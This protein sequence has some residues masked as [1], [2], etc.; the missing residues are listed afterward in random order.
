MRATQPK[1][2]V[3]SKR[4]KHAKALVMQPVFRTRQEKARKGKGSYQRQTRSQSDW[5]G[6]F[7]WGIGLF[8]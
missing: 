3:M 5:S 2:N 1:E 8:I 4:R 6:F 7:V